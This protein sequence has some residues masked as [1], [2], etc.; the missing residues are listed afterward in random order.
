[1]VAHVEGRAIQVHRLV[2]EYVLGRGLRDWE[3]VHHLN[4]IRTDNRPENLE[5]WVKPPTCGQRPADLARWVVE[6]YP[7]HVQ[8]AFRAVQLRL[9][10]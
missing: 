2:M 10:V 4:G 7:E 5:L 6:Y 3:N 9:V 1:L 8:D